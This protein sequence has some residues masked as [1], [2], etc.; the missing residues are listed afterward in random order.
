MVA[1]VT[2]SGQ[3]LVKSSLAALGSQGEIGTSKLGQ[4]G[5]DVIVNAANGNLIVQGEKQVQ[6]NQG[7][8]YIRLQGVIRPADIAPDNTV[9]SD[10]VAN[11]RI[12]YTGRGALADAN[13][14]GWLTR[15]FSSGWM[16]F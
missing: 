8:E 9:T 2:G 1:I 16:P 15:F 12:G 7:S 5:S 13:M 14:Q 3:G 10:R 4:N 11:A 6:I